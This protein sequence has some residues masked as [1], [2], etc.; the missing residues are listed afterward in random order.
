MCEDE[1]SETACSRPALQWLVAQCECRVPVL[2]MRG[3]GR[4][5]EPEPFFCWSPHPP[6]SAGHVKETIGPAEPSS[7]FTLNATVFSFTSCRRP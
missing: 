1:A 3:E 6:A 5:E 7:S 4:V 2:K